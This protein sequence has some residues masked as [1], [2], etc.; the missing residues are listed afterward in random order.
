MRACMVYNKLESLETCTSYFVLECE[1]TIQQSIQQLEFA[2]LPNY[3]FNWWIEICQ[4]HR[5]H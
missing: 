3:L 2:T 1:Q 5:R 4:E